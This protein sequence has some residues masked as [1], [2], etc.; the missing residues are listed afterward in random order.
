[1]TATR[2]HPL[3]ALVAPLRWLER[4]RGWRR[5]LL[6]L[7]YLIVGTIAGTL[8]WVATSLNA[9]PD[10]GD[11]FDVKAF[12]AASKVPEDEDAFVL[13]RKAA[14]AFREGPVIHDYNAMWGA[15][16]GGWSKANP[17]VRAW[18]EDNTEALALWRQATDRPKGHPQA[19]ET[20]RPFVDGGQTRLMQL[21]QGA[22][23]EGSR[24]E[25]EG[26]R[27]AALGWYL[28]AERASR[29]YATKGR[30]EWRTVA[31]ISEMQ[32]R[33][34]LVAWSRDPKVEARLLRQAVDAM[35]EID[36]T[37]PPV[38]DNLKAE[39]VSIMHAIDDMP[40]L[41]RDLDR[42]GSITLS[43]Q[44]HPFLHRGYWFFRREPERSRR[45]ARLFFVNWLAQCDAP[46]ASRPKLVGNAP[47]NPIWGA[48]EADPEAP[49]AARAMVPDRM[50]PWLESTAVLWRFFPMYPYYGHDFAGSRQ[51]RAVLIV[52]LA[53]QL[54]LRETGQDPPSVRAMVPKYLK[55]V[56]EGY[57]VPP[58]TGKTP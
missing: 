54:Y 14:E 7:V 50:F 49:Y 19:L 44:E 1:M 11:P 27:E 2:V 52:T 6:I 24:L 55:A 15:V 26:D 5:R 36:A 16:Q 38:S 18:V 13:Y 58:P 33:D 8:I 21:T 32:C 12:I 22:L 57:V 48:Y 39:Y 45:V 53:E 3:N 35:Q 42:G 43:Y 37:W 31:E 9:L 10:V 56:P 40:R 20:I 23:I 28:A 30:L 25:A 4:S 29:H 17:K 46:L 51:G 47:R 41:M 34:R